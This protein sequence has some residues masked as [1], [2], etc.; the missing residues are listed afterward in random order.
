MERLYKINLSDNSFLIVDENYSLC[1]FNKD[2]YKDT[3]YITILEYLNND[4][5][6][7][8]LLD[9][10]NNNII[11]LTFTVEEYENTNNLIINNRFKAVQDIQPFDLVLGPDGQSRRV[12]SLHHNEDELYKIT[13]ASGKT[14]TVNGGHVLHLVDKKNK[15]I[16]VNVRDYIQYHDRY[17]KLKLLEVS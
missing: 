7:Y 13:T 10:I 4:Y 14:V 8:I 9:K 6:D 11:P 15:V 2:N 16:Q 1:L 3:K 17:K 12:L 5:S